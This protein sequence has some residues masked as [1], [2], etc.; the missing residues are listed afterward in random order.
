MDHKSKL[1]KKKSAN[2]LEL[3][4]ELKDELLLAHT[5][6][7][8]KDELL[9][10]QA[11]VAKEAVS[12]WQKAE[13]ENSALKQQLKNLSNQKFQ[14]EQN[15]AK[16][17][18]EKGEISAE[19]KN[20]LSNQE[21]KIKNLEE[22][23]TEANDKVAILTIENKNIYAILETKE[24][25]INEMNE[26]SDKASITEMKV[27]LD[28]TEKENSNLKFELHMAQKELEI[29]N[30]ERDYNIKTAEAAYKSQME[31]L[32][33]VSKLETECN[34]LRMMLRKRLPGPGAVA[35]MRNEIKNLGLN[36]N[37]S[38]ETRR[39]SSTPLADKLHVI[40]EENRVL[41]ETLARKNEDT[42]S[43]VTESWATTF[44]SELDHFKEEKVEGLNSD[45]GFE[46]DQFQ[47]Y[48]GWLKDIVRVILKH[49]YV[50]QMSVNNI[51][52]EV[53]V[54]L[55]KTGFYTGGEKEVEKCTVALEIMEIPDK[56]S[57]VPER[58]DLS[59]IEE[60]NFPKETNESAPKNV[61]VTNKPSEEVE[62][63]GSNDP[64]LEADKVIN[65]ETNGIEKECD[66]EVEGEIGEKDDNF[67]LEEGN[68]EK[69]LLKA[70]DELKVDSFKDAKKSFEFES[71][72]KLESD[73]TKGE[74]EQLESDSDTGEASKNLAECQEEIQNIS[75]QLEAM[76]EPKNS[77]SISDQKDNS[78][79]TLESNQ[80]SCSLYQILAED[81]VQKAN[82]NENGAD[83]IIKV[84][85]N[86]VPVQLLVP[87][88]QKEVGLLSKIFFGRKRREIKPEKET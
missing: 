82:S 65:G 73:D 31:S 29:R 68:N 20:H 14:I 5:E 30:K 48:P 63:Q 61:E 46:E 59:A 52:E 51:I 41:K 57:A 62:S 11:K 70:A 85:E 86:D 83:S 27:R 36:S 7:D 2:N 4:Q 78:V 18:E 79:L 3:I 76:S 16:L 23:L 19:T 39:K 49:H 12:G 38:T 21:K 53:L 17:R 77:S 42:M 45:F 26:S 43:C 84:P 15:F 56:S 6:S 66:K 67:K 32:K 47:N 33:K 74:R 50:I 60:D 28:A 81:S 75:K 22:K 24:T 64:E 71:E 40:E 54:A 25:I 72:T 44:I 37:N 9:A 10:K 69:E 8:A 13:S 58:S 87:K 80:R 55:K 88:K 34:K 35:K 1:Q